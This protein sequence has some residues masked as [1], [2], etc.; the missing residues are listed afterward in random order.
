[1]PTESAYFHGAAALLRTTL[2]S[3]LLTGRIHRRDLDRL[4]VHVIRWLSM[5]AGPMTPDPE[6][7]EIIVTL[8][9]RQWEQVREMLRGLPS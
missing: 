6:T 1:M 7:G 5:M 3:D 4:P 8:T 9:G 2:M